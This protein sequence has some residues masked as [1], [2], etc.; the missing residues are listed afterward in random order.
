MGIGAARVLPRR[1][2]LLFPGL[3]PIVP[4]CDGF[5]HDESICVGH[6]IIDGCVAPYYGSG[7]RLS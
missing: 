1:A 3:N 4:I 5:H 2:A 7:N 6:G